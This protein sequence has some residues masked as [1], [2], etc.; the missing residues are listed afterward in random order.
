MSAACVV[1]PHVADS[2]NAT[3]AQLVARTYAQAVAGDIMDM[4]FDNSTRQVFNSCEV[5]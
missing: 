4:S 5:T 2:L 1:V 3:T